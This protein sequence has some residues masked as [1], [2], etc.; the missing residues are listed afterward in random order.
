[1]QIQSIVTWQNNGE[2]KGLLGLRFNIV[3]P[4]FGTSYKKIIERSENLVFVPLTNVI[5]PAVLVESCTRTYIS[6]LPNRWNV[7]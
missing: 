1:M 2:R 3:A 4:A 5:S 6:P 7:D